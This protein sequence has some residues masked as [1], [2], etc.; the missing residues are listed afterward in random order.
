VRAVVDAVVSPYT[1]CLELL[2]SV[3]LLLLLVLCLGLQLTV[4][5]ELAHAQSSHITQLPFIIV[6]VCAVLAAAGSL[7][8]SELWTANLELPCL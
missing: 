7:P 2:T 1:C 8:V 4:A 3:S 6:K 5:L